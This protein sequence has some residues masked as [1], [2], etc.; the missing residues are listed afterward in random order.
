MKSLTIRQCKPRV[1][2]TTL[3]PEYLSVIL[4]GK[5]KWYEI[6]TVAGNIEREQLISIPLVL[7]LSLFFHSVYP[8]SYLILAQALLQVLINMLQPELFHQVLSS[9]L[10]CPHITVP[11]SG[12]V[13]E[14]SVRISGGQGGSRIARGTFG[15]TKRMAASSANQDGE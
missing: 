14:W 12:K 5:T 15:Y 7:T 4:A 11:R 3:I 1:R 13:I 8:R 2:R 6:P 10:K 9:P